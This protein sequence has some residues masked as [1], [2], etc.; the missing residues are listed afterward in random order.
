M[1]MLKYFN[2][3]LEHQDILKGKQLIFSDMAFWNPAELIGCKPRPLSFDLFDILFMKKAW[4]LGLQP[5]GYKDVKPHGLMEK[6]ITKP[7]INVNLAFQ[8]LIPN[9][10]P[11]KYNEKLQ[12][13]YIN[14]LVNQGY[15]HDKVEF[16]ILLSAFDF[17][18][19]ERMKELLDYDFTHQDIS[20][21]L[22]CLAIFTR[23]L[24]NQSDAFFEDIMNKVSA[25]EKLRMQ[26][27]DGLRSD[28][29]KIN[30][31][32]L[33]N[34]LNTCEELGAVS[35]AQSARLAFIAESLLRSL[36][37]TNVITKELYNSI[38]SSFNTV[39]YNLTCAI[40]DVANGR[41]SRS[42]FMKEYG[43]LRSG[44]Y[45]ITQTRYD[46]SEMQ[47][48][49]NKIEKN[50]KPISVDQIEKLNRYL[51]D[52]Q[53][54]IE[55][56]D[57]YVF[58]K[59]AIE[60]R[61]YVKLIFTRSVSDCLEAIAHIGLQNDLSRQD[62]SFLNVE[63]ILSID[64]LNLDDIKGIVSQRMRDFEIN[65][66][67]N[68]PSLIFNQNDFSIIYGLNSKP[69]FVSQ[70]QITGEIVVLDHKNEKNDLSNRIVMIESA[71]PGYHWIFNHRI[72]ALIT[73]FGG[74]ASHM[75]I[76]CAEMNIPA[77][78]GCGEKYNSLMQFNK[79]LLDCENEIIE[80]IN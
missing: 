80:G 67:I 73:K 55:F 70:A 14:K 41:L 15:L 10:I 25:L 5:L 50:T 64:K 21:I 8:S 11:D 74:A 43:H 45:D 18:I 60:L 26:N 42:D 59:K 1:G 9:V 51:K 3:Y 57:L 19:S 72:K 52:S 49:D 35:F 71:D 53:L 69:N 79:I 16:E 48:S 20:Y 30:I 29:I 4:R 61:E 7:Y 31:N 37:P 24:I 34:L 56:N 36:I 44:T 58:A 47:F 40:A 66:N 27:V 65:K 75:A 68:L 2:K 77:A 22:D 78:I 28:N 54:N 17:N 13:Y 12:N 23:Q 32:T 38:K 39:G 63:E 33:S 62:A 46:L 76:C 6:F